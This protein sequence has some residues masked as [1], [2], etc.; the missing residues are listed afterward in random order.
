MLLAVAAG[1]CGAPLALPACGARTGLPIPTAAPCV[2]SSSAPGTVHACEGGTTSI[3]GTVYD[4]AGKNPLY[5]V[6][7]YVPSSTPQPITLGASCDSCNELYTGNPIATAL[8]DADGN[9]TLSGVPDGADIPLVL[10]IGKWRRQLIVPSVV[11]CQENLQPDRS[12]TLPRNQGEGDIPNIAVSTGAADTLECLFIR[13]GIDPAEY[14]GGPDGPGRIHIFAGNADGVQ[15]AGPGG[16]FAGPDGGPPAPGSGGIHPVPNTSPP[17]PASFSALWDSDAD[18]LRYDMVFLSCEGSE[19]AK[20]NRQVLF[21]FAAAGGRV[22]ASHFHYAWFDS[23]PFGQSDLAAWTPGANNIGDIDATIVTT[24]AGGQPFPQ[25]VAL[26]HWLASTGALVDGELPI[27]QARHNADVSAGDSLS[28]PWIVADPHASVPGATQYFSFN[29]PFGAAPADQ[30][31]QV[32]YTDAHVAAGV[33]D[34]V[35]LPVPAECADVALSPQEK[36]IEFMLFNLSSCVT[37][38]SQTP[39]PPPACVPVK[40]E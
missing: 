32:V 3:R 17:G 25:G 11:A 5:N 27:A 21:D 29:T 34:N 19:T 24:L 40:K 23:A 1:A 28:Q 31:G 4:P 37:P 6:V 10:Q 22:F 26:A 30:C 16:M 36:A 15:D 13:A 12:L 8:T 7:V 35:S 38:P 14:G 33:N 39:A 20:L 9:F 18:I 2:V